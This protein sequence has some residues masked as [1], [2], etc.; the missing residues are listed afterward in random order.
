MKAWN[1]RVI[2]DPREVS[3]KLESSL[4][5]TNR[6][7]FKMNSDKKDLM[8]FKIRKRM[9]LGFEINSQNN[10]IVK[11][12]IF[13]GNPEH[14]TV[15]KIDFRLHP[16]SKLLLYGHL[17]LGL[18]LLAAMVVKFGTNTYMFIAGGI[19]LA[20]GI[21]FGLHLQKEFGNQIQ[22]YKTLISGILKF[23]KE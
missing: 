4:G 21:L 23:Q 6:F 17:I 15:V 12:K 11:G 18:G 22:E 3:R 7:V 20:V 13:K 10:L 1:F 5:E 8:N 19:L 2:G 16:L 9:L 14:K